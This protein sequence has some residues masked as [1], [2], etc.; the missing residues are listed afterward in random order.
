MTAWFAL[1]QG[2]FRQAVDASQLGQA[3]AQGTSAPVQPFAQ[4]AKALPRI[5]R[6]DVQASEYATSVIGDNIAPDGT[7]L[8]PMRISECRLTL[9]FVAGRQGDLEQAVDLGVEGLEDGRQ[10]K[11]HLRMIASELDQELQRRFPGEVTLSG[12]SD[13]IRAV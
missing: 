5:A 13:A 4:E 7:E 11:V 3:V 6:D 9:A 2:R 8:S 12:L 1:T 10:S